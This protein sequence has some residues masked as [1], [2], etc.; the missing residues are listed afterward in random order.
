M[1]YV[2]NVMLPIKECN[3]FYTNYIFYMSIPHASLE[4]LTFHTSRNNSQINKSFEHSGNL[5]EALFVGNVQQ[6]V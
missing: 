1:H 2:T 5:G 4:K 6:F 3:I